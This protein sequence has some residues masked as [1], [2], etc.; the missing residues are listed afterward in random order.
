[1]HADHLKHNNQDELVQNLAISSAE[2]AGK[3]P[4]V[5]ISEDSRQLNKFPKSAGVKRRS[6]ND[7]F[8]LMK[9]NTSSAAST[10]SISS[11]LNADEKYTQVETEAVCR[12][13]R[14]WR[15]W[16]PKLKQ[17]RAYMQTPEA[18]AIGFF[19]TLSSR[20]PNTPIAYKALLFTRGVTL[21]LKLP[22]FR[23]MIAEQHR[24]IMSSIVN[25]EIPDQLGEILDEALQLSS[26]VNEILKAATDRMTEERLSTLTSQESL[27]D[28]LDF[29]ENAIGDVERGIQGAGK[30]IDEV[31]SPHRP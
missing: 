22:K 16:I 20:R 28:T 19:F 7:I 3:N 8:T 14:F 5:I 1:M 9:Q 26:Q 31:S 24:T 12:I 2:Y 15:A 29:V 18:K 21:H 13:Q 17:N 11:D 27:L 10:G 4:L 6:M 25:T 23:E 30:M